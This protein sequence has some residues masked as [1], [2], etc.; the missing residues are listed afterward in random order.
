MVL[1][2]HFTTILAAAVLI[3]SSS[4]QSVVPVGSTNKERL[5]SLNPFFIRSVC[6]SRQPTH[7]MCT[8]PVL[9]P[10]SSGQSVVLQRRLTDAAVKV[11]IPSSSGQSVVRYLD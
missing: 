9:I 10:S 8:S 6:G 7:D 5:P 2:K 3:P 4:G 11:L 1:K